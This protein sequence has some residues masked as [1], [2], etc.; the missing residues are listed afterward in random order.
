[1]NKHI[2]TIVIATIGFAI[3]S[4]LGYAVTGLTKSI[5][6]EGYT[7]SL[8][9][10][11]PIFLTAGIAV[12]G[13]IVPMTSLPFLFASMALYGFWGTFV[14]Y[15]LGN[16]IIAPLVDYWLAKKYGRPIVL[17]LAGKKTINTI[18]KLSEKIGTK[19]LIL[20][21][22]FGGI[23]FDSLSYAV[24]L[25]TYNFKK[26]FL[27]TA[28]LPIPGMLLT[29]YV[30]EKGINVSPFYFLFIIVWSYSAGAITIYLI[31]KEKKMLEKKSV[32][33]S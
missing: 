29:I 5:D 14:I 7:K 20:L 10:W 8:G 33:A 28:T 17:K 26:Y 30:L 11:G 12:G 32:K 21:R 4:L 9:I 15:Y 22:L 1:M 24:G 25:T 6:V 3:I 31:F 23:L 2:K 19:S 16:T 13:I 18:D 27:Y